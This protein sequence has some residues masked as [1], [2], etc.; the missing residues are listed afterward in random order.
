MFRF[1]NFILTIFLIV[2]NW[3]FAQ[4]TTEFEKLTTENGASQSIIYDLKQDKIGNVWMATE[5]GVVKYNSVFADTYT[6]QKGLPKEVGN[7]VNTLFIDSKDRVWLGID[8]GICLYD[9]K[10]DTFNYIIPKGN[11]KPTLVKIICE[12]IEGRIWIGGYNGLWLYDPAS[13]N[14]VNKTLNV[15]KKRT[16]I[17]TMALGLNN[18]L[19]LG[20]QRG[21]LIYDIEKEKLNLVSKRNLIVMSVVRN[22][23][24]FLLGTKKGG[25]FKIDNR[26]QE[27]IPLNVLANKFPIRVITKDI[28][29]DFFIGTDGA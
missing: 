23:S 13:S 26:F 15:T 18:K 3:A 29:G 7:R 10:F 6:K 22:K 16:S 8:K 17:Q 2:S 27:I 11:L 1:S 20:T 25:L 4:N 5:E 24:D 14:F 9:A 21:L 19:L 28:N 12:D